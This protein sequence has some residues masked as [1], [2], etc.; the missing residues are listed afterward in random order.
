MKTRLSRAAAEDLRE[1]LVLLSEQSPSAARGFRDR[2]RRLRTRIGDF[3]ESG[4]TT[5]DASLRVVNMGR[6]PY[7][8][9]F[10]R[11]DTQIV[12]MRIVHGARDPQT[13][14]ARPR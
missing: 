1:V 3:P 14:P 5:D 11:V 9:F 12:I 8:V 10:E 7:L 6:Y 4:R 2:F 13:L